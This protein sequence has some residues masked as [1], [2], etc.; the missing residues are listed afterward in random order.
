[1]ENN[2]FTW[3]CITFYATVGQLNAAPLDALLGTDR[4]QQSGES[5][6]EVSYDVMNSSLDI[7]GMRANDAQYSG[8]N[9]G[10]YSGVHLRASYALSD[11][12]SLHGGYWKR[13]ISYRQDDESID[14]WQTTVQYRFDGDK[15]SAKNYAVRFGTWGN[16]TD[17]LNKTSPSII[18]GKTFSSISVSNPLDFQIQLDVIGAWRISEETD[19]SAFS[20]MGES[21]VET[22]DIVAN[23][24]DGSGCAYR[25]LFTPAATS[26]TLIS[27]CASNIV[28]TDFATDQ[29]VTQGFNYRSSYYQLGGAVKWHQN[30]WVLRGG[31]QFQQLSR[32][33]VDAQIVKGGGIAYQRNHV[34]VMDASYELTSKAVVFVR[35]Q[36][37]SNQFV[38]EIPFA[39][40]VA[41]ASKFNRRYGFMSAGANFPF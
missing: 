38:G 40:N 39:Y 7:L 6:L 24:I 23:Y 32:G 19:V 2:T 29:S 35:F 26:G 25:I 1:M 5:S 33:N 14:S 16:L 10:D 34:F 18:M 11:I 9:V 17:E 36:V 27:P 8:T 15:S 37:M 13:K 3:L 41:T 20:G 22:G 30:E 21:W 12:L 4:F 31:Y 28:I